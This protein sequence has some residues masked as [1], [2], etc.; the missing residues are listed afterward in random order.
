MTWSKTEIRQ[1]RKL[2]LAPLLQKHGVPLRELLNQNFLVL[3]HGDLTVRDSFWIWKSH[4][5]Q[6]N[7][8]DFFTMVEKLSFAQTM[9]LLL[10][11]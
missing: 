8:I 1:A 11:K 6:G 2:P 10:P 3:S 5:L 9:Q 7:T 4:Q